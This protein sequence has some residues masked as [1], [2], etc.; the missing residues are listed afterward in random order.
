[1]SPYTLFYFISSATI[2][3]VL[4]D[5]TTPDFWVGTL[6]FHATAFLAY[7]EGSNQ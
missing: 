7:Y 6:A 5:I 1:M 4:P 3:I 2:G